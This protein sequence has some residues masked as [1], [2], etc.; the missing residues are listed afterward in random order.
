MF[1]RLREDISCI[2]ERDPADREPARFDAEEL[3]R[4]VE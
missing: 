3:N 4:L 1:P 2:L